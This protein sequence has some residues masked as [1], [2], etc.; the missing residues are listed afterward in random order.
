VQKC[1]GLAGEALKNAVEGLKK[2][3]VILALNAQRAD[4][5]SHLN[6]VLHNEHSSAQEDSGDG[7]PTT[8]IK[9]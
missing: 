2:D 3:P 7:V 6:R 8:V 4:G 1:A 9:G 5:E